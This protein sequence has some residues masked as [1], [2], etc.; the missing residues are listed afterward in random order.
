MSRIGKK[1]IIILKGVTVTKNGSLLTVKGEKGELTRTLISEIAVEI[2]E[3]V[4]TVIPSGTSRKTPALWG[5]YR[6]LIQNM[7]DGV[8]K[9]FE[10]RLEIEGVGYRVA[11]EGSNLTFA[12]GFSHPVKFA[13]PAG[14]TFTV[15]KNAIMIRGVDKEL[16]G[17][18]AAKIR[19]LKPPEPY[20]GKGI[21]YAGE[22]IRRKAGKK[23]TAAGG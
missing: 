22:V 20:K 23:A 18:T 8:A 3:G 14:I 21:R 13:A 1:P 16:V 7:I 9:G 2:A 12:L 11:L 6:A 5:L 4:L 10:K 15:E 19:N 17:E